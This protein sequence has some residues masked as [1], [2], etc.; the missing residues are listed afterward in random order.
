[1]T[2]LSVRSLYGEIPG[3]KLA[4]YDEATD[5]KVFWLGQMHIE[6]PDTSYK[7]KLADGWIEVPEHSRDAAVSIH[8]GAERTYL[9]RFLMKQI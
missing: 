1:M 3:Y 9:I 2:T 6:R 5:G 8:R 4:T 7:V